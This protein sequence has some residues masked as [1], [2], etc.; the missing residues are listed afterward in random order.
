LQILF[1][2]DLAKVQQFILCKFKTRKLYAV[3]LL[4][5]GKMCCFGASPLELGKQ[6]C[7]LLGRILCALS[8][9]RPLPAAPPH[10]NF[11]SPHSARSDH[12]AGFSAFLGLHCHL[13]EFEIPTFQIQKIPVLSFLFPS[14][15][16]VAWLQYFS[17]SAY[18]KPPPTK[19]IRRWF[20]LV[21]TGMLAKRPAFRHGGKLSKSAAISAPRKL[22]RGGRIALILQVFPMV[23]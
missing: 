15:C 2:S 19:R 10:H 21:N 16:F 17:L 4:C 20:L 13:R 11:I 7:S 1:G 22:L 6:V 14:F 5:F 12:A 18:P 3:R 23:L 8:S 9:L